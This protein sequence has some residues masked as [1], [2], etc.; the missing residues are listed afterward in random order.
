MTKLFGTSWPAEMRDEN[1]LKMVLSAPAQAV[2]DMLIPTAFPWTKTTW[3]V[4]QFYSY[5]QLIHSK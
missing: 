5:W 2:K 1:L 3:G 4:N